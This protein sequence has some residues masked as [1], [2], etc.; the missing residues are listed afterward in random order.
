[1]ITG[2]E[3]LKSVIVWLCNTVDNSQLLLNMV[4]IVDKESIPAQV[5]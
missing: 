2:V 3:N 1:M 5:Q 4:K